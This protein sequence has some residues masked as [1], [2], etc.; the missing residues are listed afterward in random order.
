V[1]HAQARR[2]QPNPRVIEVGDHLQLLR[3]RHA[4]ESFDLE[5]VEL[6]VHAVDYPTS[7]VAVHFHGCVIDG[8]LAVAMALASQRDDLGAVAVDL[9]GERAGSRGSPP[10]R[11][12]RTNRYAG[13]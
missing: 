7:G 2:L 8:V 3:R 12:T 13:G 9:T 5:G 4:P 1:H 11:R 6:L 10:A